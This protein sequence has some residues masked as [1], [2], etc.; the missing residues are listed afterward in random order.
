MIGATLTR[1]L[2]AALITAIFGA[3]PL[4]DAD[5]EALQ[6]VADDAAAVAQEAQHLARIDAAL[7]AQGVQR[8]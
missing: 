4:L 1:W 3:A 7:A 2:V 5:P 8:P 6:D